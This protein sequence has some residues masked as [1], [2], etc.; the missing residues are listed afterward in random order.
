LVIK[1]EGNWPIIL[2]EIVASGLSRLGEFIDIY[3]V[4]FRYLPA[5][6]LKNEKLE[7]AFREERAPNGEQE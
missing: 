3:L 4:I 2:W 5:F 7:R 6:M 1:S